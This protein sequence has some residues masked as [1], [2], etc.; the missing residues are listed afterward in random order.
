MEFYSRSIFI[1]VRHFQ[2]AIQIYHHS[3]S[4]S[5]HLYIFYF[6]GLLLIEFFTNW[7]L[8]VPRN[9]V[10]LQSRFRRITRSSSAPPC[11]PP[12]R[13]R[14]WQITGPAKVFLSFFL[15]FFTAFEPGGPAILPF[16]LLSSGPQSTACIRVFHRK[17][18]P[19]RKMFLISFLAK[20]D[21]CRAVSER[22]S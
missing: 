22:C 18:A 19:K 15:S 5:L 21:S 14:C 16:P 13:V 10:M 12:C 20:T 1:I 4:H 2:L 8:F 6:Y 3:L 9:I 17:L 11:N 7:H